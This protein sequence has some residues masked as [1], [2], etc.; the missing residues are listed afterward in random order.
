MI[1]RASRFGSRRRLAPCGGLAAVGLILAAFPIGHLLEHTG[2]EPFL[3]NLLGVGVPLSLSAFVICA[4]YWVYGT[5]LESGHLVRVLSWCVAG[6]AGI[7]LVALAMVGHFQLEGIGVRASAYAI[8]SVATGGSVMGL[9]LG[10]YDA[11]RVQQIELTAEGERRFRSVFDGTLDALLIAN[12]DGEYV[13]ANPAACELLGTSREDLLGRSI[14]EFATAGEDVDVDGMWEAFL[15]AGEQRGEFPLTR[16]DGDHRIVEFAAT[17]NV[18]PGRHLSALRDVTDRK[19]SEEALLEERETVEFLNQILRHEVLNA[20]NVI[21]AD[22]EYLRDDLDPN[23]RERVDAIHA[24]GH[25]VVSVI[26]NVRSIVTTIADEDRLVDVNLSWM[27]T[28][29]VSEAQASFP[30]ATIT[31][32]GAVPNGVVVRGNEL[33]ASVFENL[34]HNAIQ[35]NDREPEV[36]VAVETNGDWVRVQIADNGPGIPDKKKRDVFG[37]GNRGIKSPGSGFGLYI[38]ETLLAHF[39]GRIDLEDNEPR[40]SVFTVRLPLERE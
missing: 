24:R 27:L 7:A 1:L 18:L 33:L 21:L 25:H 26:Q 17:A 14:S 28:E 6:T 39:G 3:A 11:R 19:A 40:G 5:D 12:D 37:K 16:A 35:H 22:A 9:L 32:E 13:D 23:G 38:A 36:R 15:E 34:L 29:R 20:M 10:V 4:A 2:D 30:D 8:A 31:V